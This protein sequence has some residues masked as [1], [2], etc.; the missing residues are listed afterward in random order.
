MGDVP[1]NL[2]EVLEVRDSALNE[3]EIVALFVRAVGPLQTLASEGTF[4]PFLPF[5]STN[6]S[7]FS[8]GFSG[9]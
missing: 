4:P 6:F 8:Q 3:D 2:A 7:L 5:F 1:V 9:F